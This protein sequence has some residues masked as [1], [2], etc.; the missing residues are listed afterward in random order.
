[1]AD[2]YVRFGGIPY[3]A[4]PVG[5]LRL[6]SPAPP[7]PWTGVRDAM[8]FGARCIQGTPDGRSYGEAEGE[9]CLTLNV[10]APTRPASPK[11]P[12]M[13]WIHGG[14][15]ANGSGDIY[16]PRWFMAGGQIVVVT[17]NYRLGAL[18]FLAHPALGDG[19]RGDVVG[20]YGLADQQAALRWV[21]DNITN[22]GGDP[23][24]VTIA[25]ESAGAMSVC[26]HLVAPGSVGLFRAAI[27]ESGPC[28][29]QAD[30]IAAEGASIGYATQRGCADVH[31]AAECLRALPVAALAQP[32]LYYHSGLDAMTGPITGT[33]ELPDDPVT[34]YATGKASRV[35]VLIG[36]NR[37]EYTFFAL[38]QLLRLGRLPDYPQSLAA[39]GSDATEVAQRYPLNRYEGNAALAYS[40]AGTDAIFACPAQQMADAL[41]QQ[42]P[43]FGYEFNDRSAAGPELLQH[44]P[45]PVGASHTLEVRY[46]FDVGGAP[47]LNP[48]Q[49]R[50]SEQM[51]QMWTTFVAQLVPRADG[52]PDWP[53][54]G[55]QWMSLE[56]PT[57]RTF[58][59]FADKHQ[60]AYWSGH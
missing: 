2:D 39:F 60:C 5:R 17:I 54:L 32:P 56:T 33:A 34:E 25:G 36:V 52:A 59:G 24:K 20:N 10:W 4:P 50:L 55:E 30:R 8:S 29:A 12:V 51:L 35:P 58:T 7:Q 47:A 16:D 15:F 19:A 48:V 37:D 23:A 49:H 14:G 38:L 3:A 46:L 44:A 9:D 13:V 26:D 1:L 53:P 27:I 43:V 28:Q 18:G 57:L 11:L 21:R 40:A 6:Q 42:A 45:F 22:F 41:A 31:F